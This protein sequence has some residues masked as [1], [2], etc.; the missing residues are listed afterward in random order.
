MSLRI[1]LA[2][3]F[4]TCIATAEDAVQAINHA[5]DKLVEWKGYS[6]TLPMTVE[7]PGQPPEKASFE[8][9]FQ[10]PGQLRVRSVHE[11]ESILLVFSPQAIWAE[12]RVDGSVRVKKVIVDTI[13]SFTLGVLKRLD[14]V[15]GIPHLLFARPGL[16]L[17]FTATCFHLTSSDSA[18]GKEVV[19]DATRT[20]EPEGLDE[21]AA[22]L[23]G[24]RKIRVVISKEDWRLLEVALDNG[25]GGRLT[26]SYRELGWDK[27]P[28][29]AVFEYK[30]PEGVPV[31][32][33]D[34]R[35]NKPGEMPEEAK[36]PEPSK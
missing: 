2:A 26:V 28:D 32:E 11:K 3:T 1:V 4:V 16:L 19:V 27:A 22:V 23:E 18:D 13:D 8:V 9:A 17:E 21:A 31:E 24:I 15:E 36:G 34:E 5:R 10:S 7:L 6:G 29:A 14:Q 33:I 20:K 12:G 35:I 25:T 30:A